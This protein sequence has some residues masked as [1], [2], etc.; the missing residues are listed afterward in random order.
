MYSTRV[1]PRQCPIMS[2]HMGISQNWGTSFIAQTE[3][4]ALK[5]TPKRVPLFSE[6]SMCKQQPKHWRLPAIHC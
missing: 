1:D 6:T 4:K 2:K 5:G 3:E